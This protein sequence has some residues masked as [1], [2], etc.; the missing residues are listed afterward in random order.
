MSRTP[1][2]RARF[3]QNFLHSPEAIER[4]VS[5]ARPR[6]LVLEPGGGG[7]ALTRALTPHATVWTWE[8]DPR[9][10]AVLRDRTDARVMLGDFARSRPPDRDFQVV[11]NIPYSATARIIDWCLQARG[12]RSATVLVQLE[13]ALKRS[14]GYGRWSRLTAATWPTH[15]WSY[16]GRV[17]ATAFRPVPRVHSGILRIERRDRPVLDATGSRVHAR[18]VEAAF[19]GA[20]GSVAA[21]LARTFGARNAFAWSHLARGRVASGVHPDEWITVARRLVARGGRDR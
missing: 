19:G 12:C 10:A 16:H 11:G 21:S 4:I 2:N 20:G 9:W 14:G 5:V 3:S 18:V 13:V 15:R 7:G 17:D 1:S 8:I 6:G